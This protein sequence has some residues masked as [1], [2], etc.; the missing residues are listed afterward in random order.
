MGQDDDIAIE[1]GVLKD[2]FIRCTRSY[3]KTTALL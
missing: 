2:I 1:I 3:D